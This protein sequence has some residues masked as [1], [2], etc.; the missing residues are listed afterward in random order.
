MIAKSLFF[1]SVLSLTYQVRL[2][3]LLGILGI[4]FEEPEMRIHKNLAGG[5]DTVSEKWLTPETDIGIYHQR[6]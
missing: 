4:R 1:Y 5:F 2:E 6:N 3:Q